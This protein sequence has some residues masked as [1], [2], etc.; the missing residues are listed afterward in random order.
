MFATIFMPHRSGCIDA[1]NGKELKNLNGILNLDRAESMVTVKGWAIDPE[2]KTLADEVYVCVGKNEHKAVY[3]FDRSDVARHFKNPSIIYSG[4]SCNIPVQTLQE[5]ENIVA[6]KIVSKNNKKSFSRINPITII[7]DFPYGSSFSWRE[8]K[9]N[10]N[11]ILL[12][13]IIPC[14]NDGKFLPEALASVSQIKNVTYEVIII[15]DGST[16]PITLDYL[17]KLDRSKYIIIHQQNKGVSAARNAGIRIARGKYILPLD[18][19]NMIMPEYA[20]VGL[21]F[22]EDNSDFA[23]FYSDLQRFGLSNQIVKV[24]EFDLV[25]LI[26]DNCVENCAFY[27]KEVWEQCGGYDEKMIGFEDWEF[28]IKAYENNYK[29]YHWPEPLFLYRVKTQE[30]SLNL[31]CQKPP[32]FSKLLSYIYSKHSRLIR[33]TLK[34]LKN[35]N[36]EYEKKLNIKNA[37]INDQK[38]IIFA[39][40]RR[41]NNLVNRVKKILFVL[42]YY[43]FCALKHHELLKANLTILFFR[44]P[45]HAF[46]DAY[47]YLR[48][49]KY[50][51]ERYIR[52]SK[53]NKLEELFDDLAH[54]SRDDNSIG[55]FKVSV[56]ICTYNRWTY[57]RDLMKALENQSYP[58]FEVIVVNGPSTDKTY[59]VKELY[60][61]VKYIEIKQ[62]N[63]SVSRN[64]GIR[65]AQGDCV[66]F[67]DDDALPGDFDWLFRFVK[68]FKSDR[69]ITA[70]AGTVKSGWTENYEFYR[71]YCGFYGTHFYIWPHKDIEIYDKYQKSEQF[72]FDTGQGSNIAIR[73]K[74]LLEIGGFDEYYKYYL[75]EADVFCRLFKK[76]HTIFNLKENIGRH[77]RGPSNIRGNGFDLKWSTIAKSTAYYG[78]KNGNNSFFVRI[79]KVIGV[80][81]SDKSLEIISYCINKDIFFLTLIKYLTKYYYGGIIG[82][83]SGIIKKR[84]FLDQNY[85][86]NEHPYVNFLDINKNEKKYKIAVVVPRMANGE[87]GGAERFHLGLTNSLNT[88]TTSAELIQVMT[89]ESSFETIEDSYLRCYNLDLSE[90]DAVISTKAPT[91]IV[92]H[93]NHLCYLQHTIRIFY[94]MFDKQFP[95]PDQTVCKQR[96]MILRIDSEALKYPGIKKIFSQGYE[97]RDRLLKWNSLESEVLHPA[98]AMPCTKPNNYEYIFMPGRLHIWKRVDLLIKAMRYVQYPVHLKIAGAGEDE[99]RLQAMAGSDDRI[100]FLGHVSDEELSQLY[101]NALV[102]SFV[103]IREDYGYITLEAFAH[104]KPIITCKDSGEPLQFIKHGIN[105]FVV[106]PNPKEIAK[107]IEYFILNPEQAKTMGNKGSQDI[108]HIKWTNISQKILNILQKESKLKCG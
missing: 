25:S 20:Y 79:I 67:I 74:E 38:T 93:P 48:L 14:F 21:K 19:D 97:I 59:R 77:F 104:E 92:R 65:I 17:D 36:Q 86:G 53:N 95:D 22:L 99:E 31:T 1:I 87:V 54:Y 96:D 52:I 90:Y 62:R 9:N 6:L 105:G 56:I 88:A 81:L 23:I 43:P 18:S 91:Y 41:F 58:F 44:G 107:A 61:K 42:R 64:I 68:T 28:W 4:F 85:N 7:I 35:I 49:R 69:R 39:I 94:D 66:V 46:K 33:N 29:F 71:A 8:F 24:P 106:D 76:G 40:K 37:T 5:G 57:L 11:T 108:N 83:G 45:N 12:S 2:S 51:H 10:S 100:E 15:N 75:D 82:L 55:I 26:T 78:M 47:D 73:R 80:L 32:N 98:I 101:A 70:I 34:N 89:N 27:R 102:V 72:P 3:G 13:I 63:I 103:P 60:P 50:G 30:E 16:D 84:K